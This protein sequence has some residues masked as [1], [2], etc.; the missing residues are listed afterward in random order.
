MDVVA[1]LPA[2]P[3]PPEPVQQRDRLLH[4]P[5]VGAQARAVLCPAAGDDRLDALAPDLPPVLV[6]VIAPVGVNRI[7]AR[8][9]SAAP[10]GPI[11][12]GYWP[13]LSQGDS[14]ST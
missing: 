4:H 7:R 11:H 3:Q 14:T 1:D 9:R 5:P 10:A 13:F 6:V 12:G 8:A 2:D